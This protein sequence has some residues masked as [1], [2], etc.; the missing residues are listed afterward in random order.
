ML[1]HVVASGDTVTSIAARY[2]VDPIR[3]SADNDV[4]PDGA[5]AVGQTLVVLFPRTVH[6][7]RAVDLLGDALHQFFGVQTTG[8][9][10]LQQNGIDLH[11]TGVVHHVA[12]VG[13]GKNRLNAGG[14]AADHGDGTGGG[15][16]G[17]GGVSSGGL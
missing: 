13:K 5:L 6:A 3:L 9:Q 7:V 2:G 16:G 4:P 11:Q 12:D 17:D 15:D 10:G 14:A 1:I 8:L